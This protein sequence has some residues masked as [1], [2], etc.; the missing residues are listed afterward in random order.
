MNHTSSSKGDLLIVDDTLDNLRFLST[1]LLEQ[2]YEVRSVTNGSTAL[3]GASAQPPDLVLLDIYMPGMDGY[4]VCQHLKNNPST[5]EI[6]IIFISALNETLDKVRAFSLG[7]VDY[8]TKPFQVEEVLARIEN[9]LTLRRLQTQ[10]QAQNICLQQTEANLRRSLE[11][12]QTLNQRIKEMATLEERNRIARDIHD[13]L[14]HALVALNIQ[15]ETALTLWQEAPDRAYTFLKEAKQLG[16]EALKAVRQSVSDM[17]SD[18]L[19][20]QLLE[21]AI[22]TLTQEFHRTTGILPECRINLSHPLSI[23]INTA[24]Y[25]IVQEGLTNICKHAEATAVQI[26][27]HTNASGLSLSL[28]DNGKGFRVRENRTGFGLQGMRERTVALG[29]HLEIISELNR[30]CHISAFFPTA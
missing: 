13:S 20:G 30:G 23:Q 1:L 3:M 19:K 7:A 14:G 4:E 25:R 11:H 29:G 17:R 22:A 26:Q 6:P 21:A 5:Q 2:G 18:P 27:I 9:Q 28:Q 15:M 10:L 16:S 24:V 8:V 12:E